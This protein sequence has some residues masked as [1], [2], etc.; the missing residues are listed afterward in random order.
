[1]IDTWDINP[2]YKIKYNQKTGKM[3]ITSFGKK[4]QGRE[5]LQ[6]INNSGYLSINLFTEKNKSSIYAVHSIIRDRYFSKKDGFV[7]NHKDGNKLNNSLENLEY[8]TINEN[9]QHS[10]LI[11][12]H[13]SNDPKRSG[14]YKHGRAVKENLKEYKKQWYNE[15]KK[16]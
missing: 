12:R 6:H 1:M 2:F 5:I 16:K 13:V 10:I 7:I 8:V 11:G 14:R 15:N 9:I 4:K 3:I